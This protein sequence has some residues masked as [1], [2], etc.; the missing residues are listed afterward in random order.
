MLVINKNIYFVLGAWNACIYNLNTRKLIQIKH[1]DIHAAQELFLDP[2][3]INNLSNLFKEEH[4]IVDKNIYDN[5]RSITLINTKLDTAW[6]EI[7][8]ECNFKCIHC[9]VSDK[10]HTP[11]HTNMSISDFK[12]AIDRVLEYGI[13]KIHIIGGE[14]LIHPYFMQCMKSS[15]HKFDFSV[16][17]TNGY[18]LDKNIISQLKQL[19]IS[20]I[21]IS[22]YST[23]EE[24]YEKVTQ[25]KGSFNR[26]MR[27]IEEVEKSGIICHIATIRIPGIDIGQPYVSKNYNHAVQHFDY[28][29]A[30]GRGS[31]LWRTASSKE[32]DIKSPTMNIA[33]RKLDPQKVL[34]KMQYH[35]CFGRYIR[36][37]PDLNV[38]PCTMEQRFL[39]GNI[40]EN[41]LDQIVKENIRRFNKDY[42]E[43]CS[44]CEFRY[45][46][47]DC[48][49]DSFSNNIC[50]KPWFCQYDPI[51]GKAM[52]SDI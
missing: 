19:N 17:F 33:N 31:R 6:I 7:N 43:E 10:L 38:Y 15:L 14:P 34:Y 4:I 24:E 13:K 1:N 21:D 2:L 52:T 40:R 3:R 16:L 37:N 11:K 39:H 25:V 23:I 51:S 20:Q 29:R 18:L 41:T 49:A 36:I 46:C 28:V 12:L 50:A 5:T 30:S 9:Y 44:V 32:L 42:I 27:A 48:R 35:N 45:I 26:A 8:T 22:L 47:S